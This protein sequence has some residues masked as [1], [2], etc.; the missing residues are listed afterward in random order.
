MAADEGVPQRGRWTIPSALSGYALDRALRELLGGQS[1]SKV[2]RLIETG[3][4]ELDGATAMELTTPVRAGQSLEIL[5]QARRR[6]QQDVS[7]RDDALIHVDAHVV[8]VLKPAG[9][10]TVPFEPSE[11]NTLDR[12][13]AELLARR[14]RARRPPLGIVHRLDKET[15][16]LVVFARTL[17]AKRDLKNQFRFHTVR[18]RYWA[19]AHGSIEAR[20]ISSRLVDDRGDG[21][22]GSTDNPKLGRL[23][24]THV[25]PVRTFDGATLVE[26][27]LETGRTHQIRIHL[28]EA[29]H[30]LLG[31]RVYMQTF[32]WRPL[33]APR[34][35]L[36]AFEL[37]FSHPV[38]GEP[39]A[40]DSP[41]PEDMETC[42][43][44]LP[45]RRG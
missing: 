1:W 29:G 3:K 43:A 26:C 15:T 39:L 37:G 36:H 35:M 5:P 14:E 40:F 18:R 25:K 8:V 20:T 32:R 2:R 22:R 33:P 13:T 7:L 24:T 42:M 21:R 9:V 45:P 19:L 23:A 4:V 38:S 30:P 17:P 28:A 41:M 12:L 16:G 31:E 27:Q 10:S 11:R 44:A 6:R 34:V